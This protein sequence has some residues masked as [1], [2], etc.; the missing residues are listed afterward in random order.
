MVNGEKIRTN[1]ENNVDQ[2]LT[3]YLKKNIRAAKGRVE[4]SSI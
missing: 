4:T 3:K 1:N 2:R